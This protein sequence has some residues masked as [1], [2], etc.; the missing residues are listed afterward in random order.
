[1]A[2]ALIMPFAIL[3][4]PA[5]A[6]V[7]PCGLG[8]TLR[9]TAPIDMLYSFQP[10]T[11]RRVQPIGTIKGYSLGRAKCAILS[12]NPRWKRIP[13]IKELWLSL[14]GRDGSG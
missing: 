11:G 6:S 2:A 3:G 13:E 5:S 1:M 14:S 12:I 9:I 7:N 4:P 8:Y 10:Q